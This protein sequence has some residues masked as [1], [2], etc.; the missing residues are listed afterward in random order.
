LQAE[1]VWH[2]FGA[3]AQAYW[4]VYETAIQKIIQKMREELSD[5]AVYED[6]ERLNRLKR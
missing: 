1:S 2:T 4:T 3:M 5:S 6:F